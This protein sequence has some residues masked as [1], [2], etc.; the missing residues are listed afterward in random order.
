MG[1]VSRHGIGTSSDGG[2]PGLGE[3]CYP[4]RWTEVLPMSLD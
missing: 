1:D 4:C 2:C 3:K